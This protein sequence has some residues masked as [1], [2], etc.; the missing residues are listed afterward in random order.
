M[1]LD[2]FYTDLSYIGISQTPTMNGYSWIWINEMGGALGL[3]VEISFLSILELLEYSSEI[4][5]ILFVV[6][7]R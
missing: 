1:F 5:L 2:I 6:I 3:F 4:L 7:F